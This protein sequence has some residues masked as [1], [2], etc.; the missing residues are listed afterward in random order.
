MSIPVTIPQIF[1]DMI[2]RAI[3]GFLFLLVLGFEFSGVDADLVPEGLLSSGSVTAIMI[4]LVFG[5]LSYLMGWVLHAFTFLSAE[6]LV[7]A[8]HNSDKSALSSAEKYNRIRIKNEAVG[9]RITKLRAEARM[10]ETSRT[11]MVFASLIGA[12]LLVLSR[13]AWL[14]IEGQS[15]LGWLCKLA[16]PL[17][18]ATAFWKCERR[19]WN[20]YYGSVDSHYNILLEAEAEA[21]TKPSVGKKAA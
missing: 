20:S 11:G 15:A 16:I 3:P 12:S 14:P 6:G 4:A 1:Y 8:K 9:F 19:A 18:V 21:Q 10:L 13:T 7:R 5:I 17:I 2:A